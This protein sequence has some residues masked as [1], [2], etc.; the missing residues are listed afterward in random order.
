LTGGAPDGCIAEVKNLTPATTIATVTSAQV[1]GGP[2]GVTVDN[3]ANT[4]TYPEASSIYF[5]AFDKQ[6]AY[7]LVQNGLGNN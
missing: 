2:S 7:K 1:D 5:T 4:T 6:A 3:Y